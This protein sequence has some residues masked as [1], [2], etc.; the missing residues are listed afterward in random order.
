MAA[1]GG[2]GHNYPYLGYFEGY[3]LLKYG[4]QKLSHITKPTETIFNS[5]TLDPMSG[6]NSVQIEFFGY[7]YAISTISGHLYNHT[8]TRHG[9]GDNYAWADGHVEYMSWA[10][11]SVG[12][13]DQVDWYW[14]VTK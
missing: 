11:A 2:Y 12:Q 7:S 10:K 6:D 9:K 8:Y 14:M 4:R 3:Y 5:D 1:F 13:N